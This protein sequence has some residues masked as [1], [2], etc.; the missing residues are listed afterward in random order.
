MVD[1][2]HGGRR[3]DNAQPW[4]FEVQDADRFDI[5]VRIE[6]DNVYE[7]RHG[8]PTLIS[9]GTLLENIAIAAP[10]FGKQ[11][12]WDYLGLAGQMH[13][14]QVALKDDAAAAPNPLFPEIE[15]RSVDRRPY[16]LV[17]P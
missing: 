5:Y 16:R 9:A 8:E 7:Y 15:R 3:G 6:P 1:A 10:G 13:R 12:S 2:G 4:R 17:P 14:I 11:A